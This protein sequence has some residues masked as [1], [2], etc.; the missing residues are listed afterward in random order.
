M[1]LMIRN[2]LARPENE[3]VLAASIKRLS[4][5]QDA[6]KFFQIDDSL[7]FYSSVIGHPYYSIFYAAKAIL[8]AKGIET[9]SPWQRQRSAAPP[10]YL[11]R[12]DSASG[13][14]SFLI[15]C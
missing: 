4:D 14:R 6:K 12:A 1:D 10:D 5:E 13:R 15:P 8:L 11:G 2:Y 9:G 3:V 7:T